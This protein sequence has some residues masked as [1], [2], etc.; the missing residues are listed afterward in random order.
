MMRHAPLAIALLFCAAPALAGDEDYYVSGAGD[1]YQVTA[2]ASGYVLTSRYPKARFVDRGAA[3]YV[4]RGVETFYFGTS[5]DAAH[6]V[7]GNG[8][9]G[10]AN[11]GFGAEFDSGFRLMFPRQ[12][13][14]EGHGG[15]CAW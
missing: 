3:S 4:V 11:G 15:I 7:F 1:D 5:C 13:L 10:W 2:N 12:E 9:W 6:E 8:K 14:P